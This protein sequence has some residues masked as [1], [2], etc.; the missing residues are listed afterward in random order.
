MDAGK[1][2]VAV[3]FVDDRRADGK[4]FNMRAKSSLELRVQR[5]EQLSGQ[6]P[7]FEGIGQPGQGFGGHRDIR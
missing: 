6:R 4:T 7:G 5:L 2:M 1:G 3:I